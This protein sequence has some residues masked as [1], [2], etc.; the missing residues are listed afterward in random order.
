MTIKKIPAAK[1]KLG[2]YLNKLGGSWLKH[3]FLHSSF[4]LTDINDIKRIHAAEI[5]EVWIDTE[6]G[7]DLKEEPVTEKEVE[8][9]IEPLEQDEPDI[10]Q[11]LKKENTVSMEAA[12][13]RSR[14]LCASAKEQ[15]KEMFDDVRLGKAIDTKATSSLVSDIDDIIDTNSAAMLSIARLKTHDDYTFMH[16]I[17]VAA[18][19][20][21][22]AKKLNL[23]ENTTQLAGIAGLVHDLGKAF[24]PLDVLNKPGK[25]T[26]AEFEI[27]KK[28][29]KVGAEVLKK[30]GLEQEVVDVVLHHHEKINGAGYPDGL[31]GDEISVLARMGAIC[32]VYD[33]VTSN[34]PYKEAWDPSIAL[35]RMAS[36]EGHFDK[37]MFNV[38]VGTIGIYPIGSLVRLSSERLAVVV[39]PNPDSLITPV[40]KVFFSL[41]SKE[42]IKLQTIDLSKP[43]CKEKIEGAEDSSN[44]NFPNLNSLWQ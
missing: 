19:M 2:M 21:A 11:V 6:L 43:N 29:P 18:L 9:K 41:K 40:V 36:W 1:L 16:S 10:S 42:P 20:L 13:E 26:D 17:A 35:R 23:D 14:K 37:K 8:P 22:L 12:M 30:S 28:H 15:V 32:D 3:P 25:L 4:L 31:A 5:K 33:A 24:M 44:W 34:R 39:E 7:D 38:F 27:M